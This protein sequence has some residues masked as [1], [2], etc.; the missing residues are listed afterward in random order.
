VRFASDGAIV[1]AGSCLTGTRLNCAGGATPWGTWLSCEEFPRGRV[2]ECDP[3]G[4]V[5]AAARPAMGVFEHEAAVVDR[6]RECV[7]MT[8]DV[9]NGALYRFL[10]D[11]WGDLSSGTLQVLTG[12]R[13]DLEWVDVPDP[14]GRRTPT[15][16]QRRATRRFDRGE[17]AAMSRGRL[18]F[19]TNGDNR[20]WMLDPDTMELTVVY[21]GKGDVNGVITGADNVGVSDEG[22]IYVAEDDGDMQIVLLREDGKTLPV[23]QVTGVEGSEVTGP[24]FD[25]SGTRLYF[26]SQRNPGQTFEVSGPWGELT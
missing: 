17:G 24:A 15:R 22:V 14:T 2:W 8:E 12:P 3:V 13:E 18:V 4:A 10:P 1:D 11:S 6:E 19:T 16:R 5:P 7:Y 20:V 21:D 9:G 23:V 26:S 25:P